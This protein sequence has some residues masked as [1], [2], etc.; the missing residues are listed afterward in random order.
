MTYNPDNY[1]TEQNAVIEKVKST[2]T[3]YCPIDMSA[4]VIDH[5][6]TVQITETG[7]YIVASME[8]TNGASIMIVD[9][10]YHDTDGS[11]LVA[12]TFEI[13]RM[14]GEL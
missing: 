4:Y 1:T 13:L 6:L 11:V 9:D 3:G 12:P 10:I 7:E 8:L 14:R 5:V 2:L